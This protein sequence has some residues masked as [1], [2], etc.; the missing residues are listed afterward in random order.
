[1]SSL[2][3]GASTIGSMSS[4]PLISP[5][6]AVSKG[7]SAAIGG[8]MTM[9][10]AQPK[11]AWGEGVSNHPDWLW[12]AAG[13]GA[14]IVVVFATAL[15]SLRRRTGRLSLPIPSWLGLT[16]TA[17]D[18]RHLPRLGGRRTC[19]SKALALGAGCVPSLSSRWPQAR[20]SL[21][22]AALVKGMR[23][24]E[25]CSGARAGGAAAARCHQTGLGIGADCRN[26]CW[27]CRARSGSPSIR[28]TATFPMRL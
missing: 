16:L 14:F 12:Q 1:M 18:R 13:G 20:R 19:R 11:F 27:R 5:G 17:L 7:P 4:R 25:L 6:N 3:R 22:R 26:R 9:P 10:L 28:A 15:I 24:S 8:S 23:I 21:R 2:W